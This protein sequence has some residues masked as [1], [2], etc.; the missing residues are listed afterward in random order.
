MGEELTYREKQYRNT[1]IISLDGQL[2]DIIM[3]SNQSA[4]E[5]FTDGGCMEED[6]P[7]HTHAL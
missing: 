7:H 5:D 4:A 2:Q 3:A 1:F 6:D